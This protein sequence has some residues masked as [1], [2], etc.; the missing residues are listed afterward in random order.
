MRK[1]TR[2]LRAISLTMAFGVSGAAV[3]AQSSVNAIDQ[4]AALAARVAHDNRCH[5]RGSVTATEHGAL[6]CDGHKWKALEGAGRR[7]GE[8]QSDAARH[9]RIVALTVEVRG[10]ENIT[11]LLSAR[12]G[13]MAEFGSGEKQSYVSSVEPCKDDPKKFC[14]G[15]SDL[16][17]GITIEAIPR[18]LPAGDVSVNMV[19]D[20]SKVESL[21]SLSGNNPLQLPNVTHT[22]FAGEAR[23]APG[24]RTL[25][26]RYMSAGN[27][28]EIYVT[29]AIDDGNTFSAH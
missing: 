22:G 15:A 26:S 8:D 14:T 18:V 6:Q 17:S 23:L 9:R 12:D 29:A 11:A 4:A 10:S 3:A 27:T 16:K 25:V 19:F 13:A 7:T 21:Q 5:D 1:I 20:D 28:L 24:V 2:A